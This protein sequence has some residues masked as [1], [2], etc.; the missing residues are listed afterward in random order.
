MGGIV[1]RKGDFRAIVMFKSRK[2]PKGA[3]W[4][5]SKRPQKHPAMLAKRPPRHFD[6]KKGRSYRKPVSKESA[7]RRRERPIYNRMVKAF[8]VANPYCQ[9]VGC[10]RPATQNHHRAGRNG[11]NYLDMATWMAVCAECHMEIHAFP[12]WAKKMGYL[13]SFHA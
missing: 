7:K 8:L 2:T 4:A 13:L 3:L 11:S 12:A 5:Q 9:C 10:A 1:A 6:A